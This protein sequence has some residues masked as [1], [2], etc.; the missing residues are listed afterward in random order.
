MLK[1]IAIA[2]G[3]LLLAAFAYLQLVF[4]PGVDG[5]MN[6]LVD[7]GPFPV[8]EEAQTLHDTLYVA[9][10]HADTMMWRRD[11]TKRHERG[12]VDLPRLREGGV[13][14]QLFSTV[15]KSPRGQNFAQNSSDAPDNIT[16]VATL[17]LWP[18]RT[19]QS[20]YERAAYQAQR[21]ARIE[22]D[23]DNR[24]V[25]A[26]TAADMDQPEGTLV[27]LLLSEGAHPLEGK[28]ENVQRLFDEGYRAMG[29]Q[30]FFDNALGGSLHGQSQAGL[31]EFGV[32]AVREM[33]RLGIAVDLAH[34]SEAVSRD[35]LALPERGPVFISHGGVRDTCEASQLRNLP[36]DILLDMTARGGIIGIGYFEGAICDIT[37]TGIAR[38]IL[39]AI[40]LAGVEAVALGSDYD[41]S[42]ATA[43]DTSQLAVITQALMDADLSD[44]DIRAVMG[45]NAKRFF[46]Q[47]LPGGTGMAAPAP[48]PSGQEG[49]AANTD[50]AV[51]AVRVLSDDDM[52]GRQWGTPGNARARAWLTERITAV[53]GTPPE[54][55]AF[56]R[57][58]TRRGESRD[59]TGINLVVTLPGR[60]AGRGAGLED[61]AGQ[62]DAP[63][64]E[65]MAH[66]DHIGVDEGGDVFNGADDNA[67][68]VGALLA[69]L[70]HFHTDPPE[71][72]V[73]LL[74]LDTE[75]V[76]LAGAY[77]YVEDRMDDRP[78]VAL[79]FDMIAQNEDGEIY[80]S[81][82]SHTPALRP[83]VESAADGLPLSILFGHDR[84]EDGANDWSLSSD[85]GA[86]HAEGIPFVYFGVADHRHYHQVTDEFE[87]LPLPVY[88]RVVQLAVNTAERL[89]AQLPELAAARLQ[90]SP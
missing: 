51:E 42:V 70:D 4:V 66:Y 29:L 8:S 78:R 21:L 39:R 20:L 75:E 63:L 18:V 87:T 53:T 86:W 10:L 65:I 40:D 46:R 55:H 34:A 76:G 64:L 88:R 68:G 44:A 89:D 17:Q 1:K 41:G 6:A 24:L 27:G 80:A 83:V 60:R 74:F 12:H 2:L 47:S 52:E 25:I 13:D 5:R 36:D 61:T 90:T 22:A 59:V 56:E 54:E 48:R 30:H 11:A 45:E 82:T 31:T 9:D 58:V 7:L 73:R 81:G 16:L 77:A 43:F 14:L 15:T 33:W 84:P 57:T 38:A 26:R 69:I 62:D 79:N 50:L 49:P 32:A 35:V 72:E 3:I 23:P 85:H 28:V 19:W 67:S 71:H 37:P